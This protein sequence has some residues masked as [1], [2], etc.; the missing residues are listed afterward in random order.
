MNNSLGGNELPIWFAPHYGVEVASAM[1]LS[2]SE[3]PSSLYRYPEQWPQATQFFDQ[4]T[5]QSVSYVTQLI[6]SAPSF[7]QVEL[8]WLIDLQSWVG[9]LSE[10]SYEVA[11]QI[12]KLVTDLTEPTVL[13]FLFPFAMM[14]FGSRFVYRLFFAISATSLMV[15][16]AQQAFRYR[17]HMS[18]YQ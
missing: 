18:I 8:A 11:S 2:P 12:S 7:R 10:T 14:R 17:A 1:L 3:L 4:A 6:E 16:V 13:L 15:L 9:A 5:K